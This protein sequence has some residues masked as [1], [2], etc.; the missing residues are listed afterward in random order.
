[1]LGAFS[2][3]PKNRENPSFPLS[4]QGEKRS[5]LKYRSQTGKNGRISR[6]GVEAEVWPGRLKGATC[7]LV[8]GYSK[9]KK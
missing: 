3:C 6:G 5:V 4:G 1:M 2:S 9:S 7:S 8:K